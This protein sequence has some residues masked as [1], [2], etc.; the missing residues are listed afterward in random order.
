MG[1]A[2]DIVTDFV[3]PIDKF[4]TSGVTGLAGALKGPLTAG[5]TLYIAIFGILILLGYVRAPVQ[6]FVVNTLKIVFIVALVTQVDN[7]NFFVKDLFFTQLPE[8]LSAAL[9]KVPNINTSASEISN[10]SAFDTVINQVISIADNIRKNGSW[11]NIYPI[12]VASLYSF[13]SLIVAM[14]Y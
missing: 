4:M 14:V 1:I 10:G 5:A 11:R 9:G 13:V 3:D 7:Y 6:D 2:A 12:A 8:G